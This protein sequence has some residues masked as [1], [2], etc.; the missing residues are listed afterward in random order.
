M[1]QNQFEKPDGARAR[2]QAAR[3]RAKRGILTAVKASQVRH[4]GECGWTLDYVTAGED[5]LAKGGR[6]GR[7]LRLLV[8]PLRIKR[9]R[10]LAL[11]QE[12][13][14]LRV[15]VALLILS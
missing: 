1:S 15:A 8:A 2:Q 9:V 12:S 13:T 4:G 5:R 7:S 6:L 10:D 14:A 11:A 3:R